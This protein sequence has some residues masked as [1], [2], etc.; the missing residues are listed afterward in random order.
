[1]ETIPRGLIDSFGL[2]LPANIKGLLNTRGLDVYDTLQL[3]VNTVNKNNGSLKQLVEILCDWLKN[4][5]AEFEAFKNSIMNYMITG[6]FDPNGF[7]TSSAA[8][9]E[10]FWSEISSKMLV[11]AK[12]MKPGEAGNTYDKNGSVEP[13]SCWVIRFEMY[14]GSYKWCDL[15]ELVDE[16]EEDIP[17]Y[18]YQEP[19]ITSVTYSDISRNG[20]VTRPQVNVSQQVLATTGKKTEILALTAVYKWDTSKGRMETT[21]SDP[22]LVKSDGALVLTFDFSGVTSGT[23]TGSNGVVSRESAAETTTRTKVAAV[24]VTATMNG[25]SASESKSANVYQQAAAQN[26]TAYYGKGDTLPTAP[27]ENSVTLI[28]GTNRVKVEGYAKTLWI[29]IPSGLNAT[30]IG[31]DYMGSQV[32]L[33]T[34]DSTRISGYTLY[35]RQSS[36]N[37]DEVTFVITI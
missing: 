22:S 15:T 2:K 21:Y 1:M 19:T 6:E 29:A 31:L 10:S 4:R 32:T 30:V 25:L 28:T 16:Q 14:D 17:V 36:K 23:T 27:G 37:L 3:L 9:S 13:G 11:E 20:G 24:T 5:D 34:P 18:T 26:M 12:L 33:G 35:Y 8:F 7:I